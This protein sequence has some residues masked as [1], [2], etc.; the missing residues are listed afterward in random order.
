MRVPAV[1][2]LAACSSAACTFEAGNWFATLSPSLSAAYVPRADRNAADGPEWQKLSNDYQVRMVRATLQ[3]DEVALLA[4]SGEGGA[5][6][7]DPARP[8]PGYSL[9]HNGHCHA[10]D[11][12]LVPYAEIEA[13]LAGGR[14]AA[15]LRPIVTFPVEGTLDLLMPSERPLSC[16]PSCNLDRAT[17]LRASAPL[18]AVSLEGAV[19]DG[20][21]PPRLAETPFRWNL[22]AGA[23]GGAPGPLPV[24]EA[25]LN[26]PADQKNPP[27]VTA[28]L[29]LELAA[30]LFDGIEFGAVIPVDGVL[31]LAAA[32]NRSAEEQL[33][34]NLGEGSFL[35]VSI[36]RRKK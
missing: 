13:Q 1:V 28:L 19:R 9:C 35:A 33:L 2:W 3:L 23:D 25:E 31:D 26:L 6:S 18:A 16:K 27:G 7:F 30:V 24:V 10:S 14:A 5:G 21:D 36:F 8:P 20:R 4:S 15:A 22:R 34:E 17:I 29:R 32:P 12:R 11:G